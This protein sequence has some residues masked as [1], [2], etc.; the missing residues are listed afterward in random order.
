MKYESSINLHNLKEIK[1]SDV[2]KVTIPLL[3]KNS[4]YNITQL[5]LSHNQFENRKAFYKDGV[6]S[7]INPPS[8]SNRML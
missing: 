1:L 2:E 3:G 7:Q 6:C 4:C 5:P 8:K